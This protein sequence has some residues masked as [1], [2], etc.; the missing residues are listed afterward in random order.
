MSEPVKPYQPYSKSSGSYNSFNQNFY[1]CWR[2]GTQP[3][4][5]KCLKRVFKIDCLEKLE[6]KFTKIFESTVSTRTGDKLQPIGTNWAF[7]GDHLVIYIERTKLVDS[8]ATEDD[9]DYDDDHFSDFSRDINSKTVSVNILY[10]DAKQLQSVLEIFEPVDEKNKNNIFLISGTAGDGFYLRNFTVKL[11]PGDLDLELN[12][13]EDFLK[14]HEV[15]VKRL[16]TLND[17]G[18]VVLNG[19]PGTGK[20][21]YIKYLTTLLDKK[22]IF[23]SPAMAEGITAPN[24]LPFLLD[25]KN[26]ILVIEDAEKVVSSRES[27]DTGNGVSNILNMTDGILGDCLNIQV[28]ATLNT[29]R[30]KLDS[31]LLRKGRLIAEHEFKELPE[32][33]VKKIFKKLKVTREKYEPMILTDIYN[34]TEADIENKEKKQ[35]RMGF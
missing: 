4:I 18:L 13:G 19:K 32:E 8:G 30:E 23:V 22:I 10:R 2:F 1:Y 29:A 34:H 28:V 6:K 33:N 26:S 15:I 20:T 7:E 25:N 5:F 16:S 31:A 17:T 24:F 27:A 35:K 21:T 9:G 12:Y 14:K 11:P 3:S